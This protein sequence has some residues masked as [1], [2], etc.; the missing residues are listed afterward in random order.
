MIMYVWYGYIYIVKT[1]TNILFVY[2]H[3][4]W[5]VGVFVFFMILI[6]GGVC[7]FC[8]FVIYM[9]I[10]IDTWMYLLLFREGGLG[11]MLYYD[12]L[13]GLFVWLRH[14]IVICLCLFGC[15]YLHCR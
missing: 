2:T 7:F 12:C 14:M 13:F 3:T 10:Y 4:L 5:G 11:S 9:F 8:L 1:H 15:S 6:N